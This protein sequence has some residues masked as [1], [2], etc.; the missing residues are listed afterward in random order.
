MPIYSQVK[1]PDMLHLLEVRCNN[2]SGYYNKLSDINTNC[3][4]H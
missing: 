2:L 3:P 4:L 1:E